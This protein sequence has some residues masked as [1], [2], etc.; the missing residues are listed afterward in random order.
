VLSAMD[1]CPLFVAVGPTVASRVGAV[2]EPVVKFC[3][4]RASKSDALTGP[5]SV[6][7]APVADA[8]P[9]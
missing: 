4:M 8:E 1:H 9:P 2:I 5:F 3:P 7:D 6:T